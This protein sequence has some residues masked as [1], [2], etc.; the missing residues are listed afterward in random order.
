MEPYASSPFL[1]IRHLTLSGVSEFKSAPSHSTY[2]ISS[3]NINL[4]T[5]IRPGFQVVKAI[6][7]IETLCI[8]LPSVLYVWFVSSSLI[9]SETLL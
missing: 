6:R 7:M 1:H 4:S 2:L 8:Y 5:H 9:K 3:F